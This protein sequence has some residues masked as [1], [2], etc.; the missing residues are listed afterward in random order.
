MHL[1]SV[2][3]GMVDAGNDCLLA[4]STIGGKK[5]DNIRLESTALE[6]FSPDDP[7]ES[8]RQYQRWKTAAQMAAALQRTDAPGQT[9]RVS[10]GM[11]Q[12]P[13]VARAY[14]NILDGTLLELG[15]RFP[16]TQGVLHG[17]RLKAA[18]NIYSAMHDVLSI[19]VELPENN[20]M[21]ADFT[22]P[23]YNIVDEA[24]A[25]PR[26]AP[27]VDES[28]ARAIKRVKG[29][30]SRA[31]EY[32]RAYAEQRGYE[33]AKTQA[34]ELPSD[35]RFLRIMRSGDPLFGILHMFDLR[36][37]FGKGIYERTGWKQHLCIKFTD[38][39]AS[40]MFTDIA[41]TNLADQMAEIEGM[42]EPC[43]VA[44]KR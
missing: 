44:L 29:G 37:Y 33:F 43:L 42:N 26:P 16:E 23:F 20:M 27:P 13:N 6:R 40:P 12:G 3:G 21:P 1:R 4:V 35:T 7:I 14:A 36:K 30:D 41:T 28:V 38:D 19:E 11:K 8:V 32:L 17:I 24:A 34:A 39:P 5:R 22:M 10:F 31:L 25:D 2:I 18:R 15:Q 9:I